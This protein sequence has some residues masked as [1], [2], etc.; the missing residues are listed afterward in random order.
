MGETVK[1]DCN[2]NLID[3]D[4]NELLEN[5]KVSVRLS[6]LVEINLGDSSLGDMRKKLNT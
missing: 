1:F 5:D 6:V 2:G 3:I 4:S